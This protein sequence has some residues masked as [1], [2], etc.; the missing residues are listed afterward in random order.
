MENVK[1]HHTN[2]AK[3]LK[4]AWID[5]DPDLSLLMTID[6]I[7]SAS[8]DA[9]DFAKAGIPVVLCQLGMGFN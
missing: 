2:D 5:G 3:A 1:L 9:A 7:S 4:L 6:H 8:P